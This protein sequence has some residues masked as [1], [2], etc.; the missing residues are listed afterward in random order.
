MKSVFL[1]AQEPEMW[2][3]FTV[4]IG[5]KEIQGIQKVRIHGLKDTQDFLWRS[6]RGLNILF[7][8]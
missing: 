4:I 8:Y 6:F 7:P 3:V 2:G 1:Q 5:N